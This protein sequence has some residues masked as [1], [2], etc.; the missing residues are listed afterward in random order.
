MIF[1]KKLKKHVLSIFVWNISDHDGGPEIAFIL[2]IPDIY[3]IDSRF[4]I[5]YCLPVPYSWGLGHIVIIVIF[6]WDHLH[7]IIHWKSHVCRS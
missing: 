4:F 2:N 1:L 5:A 7:G 3:L 6:F